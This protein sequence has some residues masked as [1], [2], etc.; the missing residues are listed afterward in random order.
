ML[1]CTAKQHSA[2]P[3]SLLVITLTAHTSCPQ[4]I[5]HGTTPILTPQLLTPTV[6]KHSGTTADTNIRNHQ[7][8]AAQHRLSL[9]ME[10]AHKMGCLEVVCYDLVIFAICILLNLDFN[11]ILSLYRLEE[12]RFKLYVAQLTLNRIYFTV[13][14]LSSYGK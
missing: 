6:T 12:D 7:C 2:T 1:H 14:V 10:T 8:F 5:N 4:H 13:A 9:Y 3:S 11:V